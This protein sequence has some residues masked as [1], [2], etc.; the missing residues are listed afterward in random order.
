MEFADDGVL[1]VP[2]TT[3][4]Y[5]HQEDVEEHDGDEELIID[6]TNLGIKKSQPKETKAA[7]DSTAKAS[8]KISPNDQIIIKSNKVYLGAPSD[9]QGGDGPSP[10][11]ALLPGGGVAGDVSIQATP[12]ADD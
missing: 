10:L 6:T 12:Q 4:T 3:T 11:A 9:S 1:Q 8:K 5:A 2:G 7:K